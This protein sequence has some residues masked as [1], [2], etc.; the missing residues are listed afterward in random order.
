MNRFGLIGAKLGHSYSKQIHGLL[1]NPDYSYFELTPKE[2]DAF[3]RAKDFCGVNVTIPYKVDV[4]PYCDF[5]SDEARSIGSVNTIIN[6]GGTLL[7]F[8]TDAYGFAYTARRASISF[9]DKKVVILGSGGTS[10]TARYVVSTQGSRETVVVSRTG[11]NNYQNISI[12]NDADV[13][14]NTTPVGMYPNNLENIIDLSIFTNC[15]GVIDIVY[16]PQK[17]RLLL[18]AERLGIKNICGLPMLVA[19]AKRA[20]EIFTDTDIDDAKIEKIINIISYEMSNI[21]LVGMPGCGKTTVGTAVAKLSGKTFV[22]CDE[23]FIK[24]FSVSPAEAIKNLGEEKFR[25]MEHEVIL[26]S[27]K[28]TNCVIATGGGV[29][30]RKENYEPLHQNGKIF[31]IERPTELLPLDG[32]PLSQSK[33]TDKLYA[34]R[35]PLYLDF[36]DH[37]V[38]N[39]DIDATAKEITEIMKAGIT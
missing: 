1:G 27:G 16:N 9:K 5:I 39:I 11:E 3:M 34:E 35:L 18:D 17:T 28:R 25:E 36:S 38:K 13:I 24:M 29:V 26:E 31:F 32:R 12:H 15:K 4:M 30:T 22:D 33:G 7:G 14:V 19:Q 8:N 23:E 6:R 37:T 20:A 10:R 21:I 2:L